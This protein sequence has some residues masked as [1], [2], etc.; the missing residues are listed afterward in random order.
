MDVA[1]KQDL[2]DLRS[3]LTTEFAE[4]KSMMRDLAA[5]QRDANGKVAALTARVAVNEARLGD[6][7][8]SKGRLLAIIG[9]II[10]A[11]VG[12]WLGHGGGRP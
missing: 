11:L 3:D 5:Y 7:K 12:G 2:R 10:A 1:T 8:D 9:S 4:M 6:I